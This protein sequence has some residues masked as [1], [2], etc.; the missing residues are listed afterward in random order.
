MS[1]TWTEFGELV[2][3]LGAVA[4]ASAAWFAASTAYRGLEKWRQ[5]TRGKSRAELA[6]KA[7]TAAYELQEVFRQARAPWVLPHETRKRDGVPDAVASEPHYV[8]EAR[9]LEH[10]EF[11]G[12][13]RALRHQYA[14][15][16]GPEAAKA[17]DAL[18]RVRLD[19]N[20]AVHSLVTHKELEESKQRDDRAEWRSWY[21][22]AFRS[23]TNKDD[24]LTKRID[25]AVVQ[26]ER[27][28]RPAI[29]AQ[30]KPT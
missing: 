27:V 22:T 3:V 12:R 15:V 6:T 29:D 25:E 30:D 10:E 23:D 9:L 11:F 1:W 5:E 7:L 20:G 17:F 4:T 19:I 26:V 13:F 21:D 16:F 18:L 8:P 24:L 28:C 14:A 2:K